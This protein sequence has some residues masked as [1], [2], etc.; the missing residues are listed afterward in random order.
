[1]STTGRS[2][3]TRFG[4]EEDTPRDV[5]QHAARVSGRAQVHEQHIVPL[6]EDEERRERGRAILVARESRSPAAEEEVP[7]LCA[8]YRHR[9]GRLAVQAADALVVLRAQLHPSHVLDLDFGARRRLSNNDVPEI[10]GGHQPA[11]ALTVSVNSWRVG[12]SSRGTGSSD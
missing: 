5:A 4:S 6:L 3:S 12:A 9:P 7:Y 11:G 2:W 10:L 1:M 8:R